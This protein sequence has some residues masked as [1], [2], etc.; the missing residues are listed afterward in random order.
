MSHLNRF[1]ALWFVAQLIGNGVLM[2]AS[3]IAADVLPPEK[4][5]PVPKPLA[6]DPSVK[7]DYDIVYV[8]APRFVDRGDGKRHPSA[9][10]EIGHP[11]NIDKGYDLML[12]RPDGSEEL[13]VAGGEGSVAD[14]YVSFDAQWVYYAHFYLG[15]QGRG[16]DI[17]KIHV[18]SRETVRLTHQES[19]PNTGAL[20]FGDDP[21]KAYGEKTIGRGVY[22][23]GPCPLPGGRLA[24]TS[25]R[26]Q[27]KVPRGYPRIANQIFV[28][29]DDG[30]NVEKIGHI[31]IGSA[32][33]PVI[34]KDGRIIFSS[35]E[36][37]GVHGSI[38]WGIWA[39]HPDGSNWEPIM[40]A[41]YGS[42]GADDGFH[43]QSQ[44]SDGRL[45][46]EL[47]Y[48]Q[49]TQGFGTYFVLPPRA[50][51]G[52]PQFGSARNEAVPTKEFG[53][54]IPKLYMHGNSTFRMPFQP[55]GL[56]VLTRFTHGSDRPAALF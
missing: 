33:H 17:Y 26:D 1:V 32:L 20:V 46:I 18:K 6:S 4:M 22:N 12:L 19:T 40:S 35:L 49:N 56:E 39:I 37:Q 47:Y 13:L 29:D 48:N 14:P 44:L 41:L 25:T 5:D 55:H 27:V 31:N 11:T 9:W 30:K 42:G 36:S 21:A 54:E 10:P 24:F 52:V 8:R 43:F 28:M 15:E 2:M 3:L 38:A 7:I 23:L 45:V 53:W 34:L 16:S 51:E 50:P